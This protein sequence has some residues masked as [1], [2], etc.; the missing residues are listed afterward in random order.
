M[1]LPL[2]KIIQL[3]GHEAL[4]VACC[5]EI[6]QLLMNISRECEETTVYQPIAVQDE[7]SCKFGLENIVHVISVGI[8]S[9]YT[10]K[11]KIKKVKTKQTHILMCQHPQNLK[12]IVFNYFST[13]QDIF[14]LKVVI[15]SSFHRNPFELILSSNDKRQ[16]KLLLESFFEILF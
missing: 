14:Y 4:G 1:H 8:K 16:K 9:L 3:P 11:M 5:N 10:T 7:T 13:F 12:H 15:L 2:K 6:D